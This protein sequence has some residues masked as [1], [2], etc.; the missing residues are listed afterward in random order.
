MLVHINF[1]AFKKRQFNLY[2]SD[3][4]KQFSFLARVQIFEILLRDKSFFFLIKKKMK[5]SLYEFEKLLSSKKSTH[6]R[7][8]ERV[9][10]DCSIF[11]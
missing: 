6:T 9:F 7:K 10:S 1:Q 4:F 5:I 3:I 8:R 11:T 2:K